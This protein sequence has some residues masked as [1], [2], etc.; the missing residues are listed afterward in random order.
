MSKKPLA[1][2]SNFAILDV[3]KGRKRLA[4]E[5]H[6]ECGLGHSGY[7]IPV[8]ITGFIVGAWGHDDGESREFQIEVAG[9]ELYSDV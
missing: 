6:C 7:R 3:K 2:K 9:V 8:T 5:L 4:K 1:I